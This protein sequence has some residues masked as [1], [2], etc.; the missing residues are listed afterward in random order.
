ML[1]GQH[2]FAK[3]ERVANPLRFEAFHGSLQHRVI[4]PCAQ[5]NNYNHG[6]L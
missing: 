5:V 6:G 3:I 2:F 1:V 4:V